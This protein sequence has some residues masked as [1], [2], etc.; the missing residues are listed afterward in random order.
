M[1]TQCD[2]IWQLKVVQFWRVLHQAWALKTWCSVKGARHEGCRVYRVC[3]V[4]RPTGLGWGG[5]GKMGGAANGYKASFWGWWKCPQIDGGD[6]LH[7]AVNILKT[8]E[9]N[10][11]NGWILWRMNLS[12]IVILKRKKEKGATLG[13]S[14]FKH[15]S[16]NGGLWKK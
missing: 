13:D 16:V 14:A 6:R 5:W 1:S 15:K 3:K 8:F 7:N 9:F 2:V 10:I 11:L 4:D 12:N